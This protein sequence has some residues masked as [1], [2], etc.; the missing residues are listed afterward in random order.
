MR[1]SAAFRFRELKKVDFSS[2]R[3]S[4]AWH[5]YVVYNPAAL[6]ESVVGIEI[7]LGVTLEGP[8]LRASPGSVEGGVLILLS[9]VGKVVRIDEEMRISL[10]GQ[11][12]EKH[13]NRS[14]K[15]C[16]AQEFA[17]L[18]DTRY[19]MA[20][21]GAQLSDSGAQL[22]GS[23]AQLSGSGAQLSAILAYLHTSYLRAQLSASPREFPKFP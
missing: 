16:M 14:V 1:W 20:H 12:L 8:I 18:Y 19:T 4:E 17:M 11:K 13:N 3:L 15:P 10:P 5:G 2:M 6:A 9:A 22:S 21:T 23:G 7:Y